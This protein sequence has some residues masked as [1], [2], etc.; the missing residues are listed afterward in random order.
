MG[1]GGSN[2]SSSIANLQGADG[3][4]AE[5]SQVC[6]AT[7]NQLVDHVWEGGIQVIL[8]VIQNIQSP[9]QGLKA[10]VHGSKQLL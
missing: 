5:G 2:G 10:C 3:P 4:Q 9:V 7:L 8:A 6:I 1:Q